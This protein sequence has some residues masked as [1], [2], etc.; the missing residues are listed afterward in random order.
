MLSFGNFDLNFADNNAFWE[1]FRILDIVP[2]LACF[3]RNI[4]FLILVT[5]NIVA[6]KYF[7]QFWR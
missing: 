5:L 2:L 3:W 6:R 7:C 4:S 1:F